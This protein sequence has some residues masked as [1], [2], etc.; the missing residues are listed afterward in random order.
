MESQTMDLSIKCDGW[1]E[2]AQLEA[3]IQECLRHYVRDFR[4]TV[5]D[6]GLFCTV[7]L[8]RIT[9]SNSRSTSHGTEPAPIRAN[10]IDV[11]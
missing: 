5:R 4:L 9:A 2:L 3:D 1:N 8:G 6:D 10:N 7:A 11:L